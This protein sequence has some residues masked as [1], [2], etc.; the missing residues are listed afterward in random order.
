MRV[1]VTTCASALALAAALL[2]THAAL[3]QKP[4]P[5]LREQPTQG[6]KRPAREDPAL[7]DPEPGD[8][9]PAPRSEGSD[10][11]SPRSSLQ[12]VTS[13]TRADAGAL[14]ALQRPGK[15]LFADGFESEESLRSYFEIR[16]GDDGR[17]RIDTGAADVHSGKGSLRLTAPDRDGSPSGA[18]PVLWLGDEGHERVHLRYWQRWA[19]DY[20]Q[21][22]LNHTGGALV[23]VAGADKWRGM[24]SAG[25]RPAGDDH[26]S[27]SI[28]GSVDWGRVEVPGY[29]FAYCY[30]MDMKRDRDGNYWGNMLGPE[31]PERIVPGRGRWTCI[32]QMV[33]CNR[34]GLADGELAVWVDGALYMHWRGFRWR[35]SDEV[36]IKRVWLSIYVH[37]ARRDNTVHFDDVVVSTGYVGPEP[38]AGR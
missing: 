5:P 6:P 23:G 17:A 11:E 13:A 30:W 9:A 25:R 29:L 14:A 20:D 12:L 3:G 8:A 21:G 26:F 10:A 1:R 31:V 18:G 24:G 16:G 7:V 28:E 22:N 37:Q 27:S 33:Q 36:R 32:E 15:V 2:P 35:S 4:Q 34:P 19:E 38:A